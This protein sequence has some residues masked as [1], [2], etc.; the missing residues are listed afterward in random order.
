M[1]ERADGGLDFACITHVDQAEL[2]SE[3][4]RHHLNG[5]PPRLF[6]TPF[7]VLRAFAKVIAVSRATNT[8]R[9][10]TVGDFIPVYI[11]GHER[12]ER[13]SAAPSVRYSEIASA[14]EN[15][16]APQASVRSAASVLG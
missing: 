9:D 3:G 14:A 4:R 1:S 16:A 5:Q 15:A 10:F 11:R 6:S 8:V 2:H 12:G 13:R 7:V